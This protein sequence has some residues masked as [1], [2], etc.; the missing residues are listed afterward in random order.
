M[1]KLASDKLNLS[2]FSLDG[3][4]KYQWVL[5]ANVEVYF[6]LIFL[7]TVDHL[8]EAQHILLFEHL[9]F[10]DVALGKLKTCSLTV[11]GFVSIGVH[12]A[13]VIHKIAS[14]SHQLIVVEFVF[15]LFDLKTMHQADHNPPT[16]V[17]AID[18]NENLTL[19]LAYIGKVRPIHMPVT[20]SDDSITHTVQAF[21]GVHSK[22]VLGL[23]LPCFENGLL[24]LLV[25]L[26]GDE[27]QLFFG[28]R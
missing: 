17:E 15:V 8:G 26:L 2:M 7:P 21:T 12:P 11:H 9:H 27:A 18:P 25:V 24:S 22:D 20:C 14:V 28:V 13:V 23:N 5:I 19:G 3:N 4:A 1:Y 16:Y 10:D 6:E